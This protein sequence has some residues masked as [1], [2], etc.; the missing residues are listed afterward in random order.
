MSN[1]YSHTH[2]HTHTHTYT[3]IM[4]QLGKMLKIKHSVKKI[5]IQ[6]CIHTVIM[7]VR[8]SHRYKDFRKDA[9]M[10]AGII[11]RIFFFYPLSNVLQDKY[12]IFM[13]K[14]HFVKDE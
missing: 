8:I 3:H 14:S 11:F 6:N 7:T 9:K 4:W 1:I 2:T 10:T 13:T 12:I 5:R